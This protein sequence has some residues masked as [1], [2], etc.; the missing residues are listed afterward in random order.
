[1]PID[2]ITGR[3]DSGHPTIVGSAR[4]LRIGDFPSSFSKSPF[5]ALSAVS[6]ATTSSAIAVNAQGIQLDPVFSDGLTSCDLLV[7]R[8]DGSDTLVATFVGVSST[9][10]RDNLFVTPNEHVLLNGKSIK[11][12]AQ[13]FAGGG[14]VTVN[15]KETC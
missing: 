4:Y 12:R 1:M 3:L 9:A 15:V 11:V 10:N 2:P 6:T 8:V 14:S 13:N 5:V 7:Y